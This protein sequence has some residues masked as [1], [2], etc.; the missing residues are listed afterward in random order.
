M[1][2]DKKAL[3]EQLKGLD[4]RPWDNM[5][6]KQVYGFIGV[7]EQ[8][9][10]ALIENREFEHFFLDVAGASL[11]SDNPAHTQ[12]KNE[13]LSAFKQ[14]PQVINNLASAVSSD[15]AFKTHLTKLVADNPDVLRQRLPAI[16]AD[17]EK[18]KEIMMQPVT[19]SAPAAPDSD[20]ATAGAPVVQGDT[21]EPAPATPP[22]ASEQFGPAAAPAPA[23]SQ[24]GAAAGAPVVQGD[25]EEPAP[26]TPPT[27][28]EQ[29]GPAAAPSTAAPQQEETTASVPGEQQLA[30]LKEVLDIREFLQGRRGYDD[31]MKRVDGNENLKSLLDDLGGKMGGDPGKSL[32]T[33]RAIKSAAEKDPDFFIKVNEFMDKHP[34]K[35]NT[36]A[37]FLINNPELAGKALDTLGTFNN[38]LDAIGEMFGPEFKEVMQ[39]IFGMFIKFINPEA[40]ALLDSS[41]A[42]AAN[43]AARIRDDVVTGRT[44]GDASTTNA[45]SEQA[46]PEAAAQGSNAPAAGQDRENAP[47]PST[48]DKEPA[49]AP[50]Q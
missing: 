30:V 1:A 44:A 38:I 48:A 50:Q 18:L 20:S 24:D 12:L 16:M 5:I 4:D 27:A 19:A 25:T 2:I 43:P 49:P 33:L 35:I 9:V 26:A 22:T 23:P 46:A 14:N 28:S 36:A 47:D 11:G 31:F 40:A 15:P 29:F 39:K 17:P 10:D 13:L 7:P 8:A 32:E 34:G 45:P 21:E 6:R 37:D 3:I 41:P 42:A